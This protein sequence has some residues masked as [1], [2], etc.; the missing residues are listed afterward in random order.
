MKTAKNVSKLNQFLD[1][2]DR[3]FKVT[4]WMAGGLAFVMMFALVREVGG[5]YFFNS[6]T[7]WAIDINAFL[8]VVMVYLGSA[9]T[10][11]VDGHVRADFI[12]GQFKGKTLAIVDI[13]ISAICI[14][15]AVVLIWQ[16]GS[17]A[18]ESFRSAEVSS[19]GIRVPLFP[20]QILIPIGSFLVVLCFLSKILR[21][22]LVL[23]KGGE[24]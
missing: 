12:Y 2:L 10:T 5:R 8:F 21:S 22:L 11:T 14:A 6:P 16:G 15:Y 9:Y 1:R 13:I 18:W 7:D 23:L 24:A 3:Y 20:F 4:G 19:G 17:M